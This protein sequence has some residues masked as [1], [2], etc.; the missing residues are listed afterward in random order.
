M[1][2][3]NEWLLRFEELRKRSSG[4]CCSPVA[5]L[6]LLKQLSPISLHPNPISRYPYTHTAAFP[7]FHAQYLQ[8]FDRRAD[9]YFTPERII[10][11]FTPLPIEPPP[12]NSAIVPPCQVN[13]IS[14][15][16]SMA[17]KSVRRINRNRIE[18]IILYIKIQNLFISCLFVW[19]YVQLG[20]V[21][22]T[23][24]DASAG[25]RA[26][27]RTFSID[28]AVE[29]AAVG[30]SVERIRTLIQINRINEKRKI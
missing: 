4:L 28:A 23:A 26:E 9:F 27:Q 10:E 13:P 8:L 1:D 29:R 5:P 24:R 11:N 21:L 15:A 30:C 14:F 17:T 25:L 6:L 2:T 20:D 22:K 18:L 19:G 12:I 16:E 3:S 7:N